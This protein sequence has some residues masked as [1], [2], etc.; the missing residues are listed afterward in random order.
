[1]SYLE[2]FD[3]IE[4]GIQRT[5]QAENLYYVDLD[6][7][8]FPKR[9]V[10][11][12]FPYPSG[13]AHMGHILVY[14]IADSL[15]RLGRFKGLTVLNPIGWDAFGLPAE[16]A[17]IKNNVHPAEWTR[18]NIA[19]MRGPQIGRAG[20][21]FD[22]TKE[23]DTSSP[24]FYRW[25]QWLFLKLHEHGQVYRADTWVNW[26][27]VD[28]TVL[29]NEQ[30]VDGKGW[31]SGVPIE[32]RQMEQW[33][34]R[35][36][37]FA[38]A[39]WSGLD[40]LVGGWSERAIAAQRNWIGRSEGCEINFP[41][42]GID[43]LHIKVF[44]TRPDTIY[45]VTSLTLAPEHELVAR[46]TPT[47]TRATVEAYVKSAILKN[48]VD[49]QTEGSKSGIALGRLACNP[50]NGD[51]I[52]IYVSDYVLA[53]YGTGAIMNVP[54]HDQR[55]FEFAK[56]TG[57]PIKT[58][59]VPENGDGDPSA[60]YADE[61]VLVDSGPFTGLSSAEARRKITAYVEKEGHGK[62][63]V[64]FRLRDWSVS[65]Q[66]FWGA[67]IPMLRRQDGSWEAVPENQLPVILPENVDFA[68]EPGKSPLRTDPAFYETVSPTDG[69]PCIREVD[70]MDTFMCSAWYAWRFL[71]PDNTAEPFA[72][73]RAFRW[74][75]I[76]FYVGGLEHAN[77][78]LIYFR[79]I[80]HFLHSIGYT[81]TKEPVARFLD[82]GMIQK[83][84]FKM[85][86]SRGNVVSP[87][88]MIKQYGADALRLY[89]LSDTPY[90]RDREWDDAGLISK[91][92]FLGS[93]WTT[94]TTTKE[95]VP[96]ALERHQPRA[97]DRWSLKLLADLYLLAQD[98]DRQIEER[99]AFHVVVAKIHAF[100]NTLRVSADEANSVA[101]VRVLSFVMQNFLKVLGLFCPHLA[102]HLWRTKFDTDSSLFLE[103]WVP[104]DADLIS[105]ALS[106][107]A[108]QISI[109]GKRRHQ[110]RVAKST[111]DDELKRMID[112]DIEVLQRH[113]SG[114]TIVRSVTVR[115]NE[116]EPK[117][118][119]IV[120][121]PT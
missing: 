10:L 20:F 118:V 119:N 7:S 77:Q 12:M 93:I 116:G 60:M 64:R 55:D 31:R 79:Y 107:T 88:A 106:E 103:P 29:A 89:V 34:F 35:I 80:S 120:T 52:P 38:D 114:R 68:K 14:S 27:P 111:S 17:A 117:L 4:R 91:K 54:A 53:N 13:N 11:G 30:V 61:G 86:K 101:R 65:R 85:S 87:D 32:R 99:Q 81:P 22:L 104:I 74:M 41:V 83:N 115:G 73:S 45:G 57:L 26:D 78:H 84:G 105:S 121:R 2:E 3:D 9:Y 23:I 67:P 98:A 51:T 15:A 95:R 76:D 62:G 8:R 66:R 46:L 37:S 39:L 58:V 71:D 92:R 24:E 1:M 44:T 33:Y 100:F 43:G 40:D 94:Y 70:T 42:V 47:E 18:I 69:T 28:Q 110:I 112:A 97:E 82:N 75:P 6:D 102:D 21:S 19:R 63:T 36:T 48:E 90:V 25:T 113:L 108:V 59:I 96:L 72:R 49:R 109:D 50:L 56:R 16:N 5:W